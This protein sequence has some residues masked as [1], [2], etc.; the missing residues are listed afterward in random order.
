MPAFGVERQ[1]LKIHFINK[2]L[3]TL[4]PTHIFSFNVSSSFRNQYP[5]YLL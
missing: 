5:S 1:I 3:D 2:I 4:V